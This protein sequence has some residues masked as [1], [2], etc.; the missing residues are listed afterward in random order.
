MREMKQS[1][2]AS[3][4]FDECGRLRDENERLRAICAELVTSIERQLAGMGRGKE[5]SERLTAAIEAA[6][7]A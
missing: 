6:R 7:R 5:P 2:I 3:D 1:E 4:L